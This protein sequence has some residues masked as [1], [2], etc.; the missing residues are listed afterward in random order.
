MQRTSLHI[1]SIEGHS[2]IIECLVGHGVDVNAR[3]TDGN[4]TLHI[5]LIKKNARP[6][7]QYTPQM[8]KVQCT[9]TV[10]N[11]HCLWVSYM[12][13]YVDQSS[14]LFSVPASC[15]DE[16]LVSHIVSILHHNC[17]RMLIIH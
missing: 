4:T 12:C 1:T 11:V 5:V 3:D 13:M 14:S 2:H 10:Y 8:N 7:S 9:Y 17:L 16:N 6:L 15:S